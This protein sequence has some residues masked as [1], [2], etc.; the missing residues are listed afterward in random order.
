[1]FYLI[2]IGLG[3]AK[4][5]SLRGLEAVN[6]CEKVFLDVYTSKL[7]DFDIEAMNKLYGRNV[8]PA[9]REVIENKCEKEI[10]NHA[11]KSNAA[12]LVVGSPLSATTHV[13]ILQRAKKLGIKTEV[14]DNASIVTAVGVTGLSIYKFGRI[15]TL[16]KSNSDVRSPYEMIMKN[17]KIGL[18]TLILLDVENIGSGID[19]MSAREGLNYLIKMGLGKDEM[20]V[21]CGGLAGDDAG[22]RYGKASDVR[23]SKYPQCIIIPG[24]LH[25]MEEEMLDTFK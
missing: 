13:D 7:A 14:I 21:V 3:D 19:L 6:S 10:L 25:F 22:I 12:L 18:H 20:V 24:E 8:I 4:D 17:R 2:G 5:I 11:R 23:I 9:D 16:P 15:V 1:M